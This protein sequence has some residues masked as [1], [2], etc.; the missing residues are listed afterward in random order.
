MDAHT[1]FSV[2]AIGNVPYRGGDP[3]ATLDVFYPADRASAL[4]VV[5]WAHGG[6]WFSGS[7]DHVAP[8]LKML[9]ASGF[10]AIGVDYT[11]A[12][13]SRYPR[14]LHQMLDAVHYVAEHADELGIDPHRIVLAGD[15]AGAH[16]VAQL[17]AAVADLSYAKRI[18]LDPRIAIDDVVAT[19]LACGTF[20]IDSLWHSHRSMRWLVGQTG[21]AYVGTN[22]FDGN[23]LLVDELSV[24]RHVTRR[25]PATFITVGNADPFA[26]QS[27]A[28]ANK[29]ESLGVDVTRAFFGRE[30]QRRLGHEYQFNLDSDEG[31]STLGGITAFLR[32]AIG[33]VPGARTVAW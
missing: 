22:Q 14:Q 15:S 4:P 33:A 10:A 2:T 6:A 7:K 13:K 23:P 3:D 31:K 8:Y 5:L 11:I 32:S 20:D 9:T 24:T 1:P 21:K 26:H 25:F 19:V 12:P 28:F 29:L 17:A 27:F 16:I 18:G 30:H